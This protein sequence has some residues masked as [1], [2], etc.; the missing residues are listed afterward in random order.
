MATIT[1][2]EPGVWLAC[3]VFLLRAAGHGA[4]VPPLTGFGDFAWRTTALG[5]RATAGRCQPVAGL[6]RALHIVEHRCVRLLDVR[7]CDAAA[8]GGDGAG[9]SPSGGHAADGRCVSLRHGEA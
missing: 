4:G 8:G 7:G 5:C 1:E 3:V 6:A 2:R 9:S